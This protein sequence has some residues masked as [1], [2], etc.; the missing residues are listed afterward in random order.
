MITKNIGY[1]YP[2]SPLAK[3][4]GLY[5]S[6]C[7]YI[8]V[9]DDSR[10]ITEHDVIYTCLTVQDAMHMIDHIVDKSIPYGKYSMEQ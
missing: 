4:K 1:A 6:G 3:A 2:T 5:K 7:Y 9:Y 10:P 8:A